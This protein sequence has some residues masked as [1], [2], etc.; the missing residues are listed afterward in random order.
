MSWVGMGCLLVLVVVVVVVVFASTGWILF[1][2]HG[3]DRERERDKSEEREEGGLLL[4]FLYVLLHYYYEKLRQRKT[5]RLTRP[6]LVYR[7]DV[8]FSSC[9]LQMWQHWPLRWSVITWES[10]FWKKLGWKEGKMGYADG[11][12]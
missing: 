4:Y 1:A 7:Q 8:A 11:E 9:M 12:Q 3:C 10:S 5:N 6:S 2:R